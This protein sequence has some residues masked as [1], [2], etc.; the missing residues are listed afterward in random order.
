MADQKLPIED[1]DSWE[2][3]LER[4]AHRGAE[5]EPDAQGEDLRRPSSRRL[6]HHHQ[7]HADDDYTDDDAANADLLKLEAEQE[8]RYW[9]HVK[10]D[11]HAA[12]KLR[13]QRMQRDK[14]A[15]E[16]LWQD[17]GV[18]RHTVHGLMIDAGS[19]GSRLHVYEWEPRILATEADIQLAVAGEKLSYPGTDSR[20][21]DRLQP[22]LSSF[23]NLPTSELEGAIADY[24]KPLLDFARTVLHSKVH[25]FGDFP[26]FLRA[27]AGMRVLNPTER[28]RVITVVRDLFANKTY[29]PFAFFDEQARV[30]SG[31]EES[32]FDWAGVNFL[33]GNLIESSAGTGTVVNP[34]LTQGSLDLGGGSTQIGF[35]E[36]NEDIMSNLFKLQIGQAK[37]WNGRCIRVLVCSLCQSP[38]SK[39]PCNTTSVSHLVLTCR[40][41]V[42][43]HSFLFYGMKEAI[44]R[45]Q[46]RLT[47]GKS[48]EERLVEGVYNPCMPGGSKV[49]MR[50]N[51]HLDK[52]GVESWNFTQKYPSGNGY[53]QAF[54]K[55]NNA[56]ADVDTCMELTKDLL[57]L[58]KN[59]WCDFAHGDCSFAGIYQPDLPNQHDD[60]FG[61]FIAFSNYYHVWKFLKLPEIGKLLWYRY[62]GLWRAPIQDTRRSY[63]LTRLTLISSIYCLPFSDD[64]SIGECYKVRLLLEP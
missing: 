48:S 11:R 21:T 29:C 3:Q 8:A 30:L 56:T 19:T 47:S 60:V 13:K 63:Q 34:R 7:H 12:K 59:D 44:D 37:H 33:M 52:H 18:R 42:Y 58:E 20:W 32:I 41:P 39:H 23:G 1:I 55:N 64:Q 50:T 49:E 54:L 24:L 27:T 2:N 6:H 62:H 14:E 5:T 53:Y 61:G 28:A 36:P 15:L 25:A 4:S 22:G 38:T 40:S 26:I 46:A 16:V 51:I 35:Y 45:F 9:K 31:E 43:A 57:H 17:S 10:K